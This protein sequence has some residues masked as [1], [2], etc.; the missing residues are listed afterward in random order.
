MIG[1]PFNS[2]G[3]GDGVALAP[4]ALREAGL[5]DGLRAAGVEVRDRGDLELGP[6]SP[7]RDPASHV[8]APAA[9]TGMIRAVRD[10]VDAIVRAERFALVLGGDCPVLL[11]CLGA[12]ALGAPGLLFLDGHEDAWP[13]AASTTGEAA[14]M[15]LGF[16]LGR[17]IGGLPDDLLAE[18]PRLEPGR[19]VVIGARDATE[20]AE[21]GVASIRGI[22]EI[23]GPDAIATDG[24]ERLG[25]A[26]MERLLGAGRG[27]YHVDLDV[28]A[29]ASLRAV[30]YPQPGGLDWTALTALS[31][32]AL[33]HPAVA[34][35]D[36]IIDNPISIPAAP[37][38][39]GS[40]SS[41]WTSSAVDE[42]RGPRNGPD[43]DASGVHHGAQPCRM[44][45]P[46]SRRSRS[47]ETAIGIALIVISAIEIGWIVRTV[48]ANMP[49]G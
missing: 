14:D 35:R 25:T 34:G 37:M 6:T 4:A 23:I 12:P 5:V 28:L 31:R 30:D 41:W 21:A 24:A 48:Q 20:L 22:V 16:A 3:T 44:V 13:P 9:L 38:H 33:A 11:G 2:S 19:V 49:R 1:V 32:G 39:D 27:W 29:T 42:P 36:V 18:L 7:V 43:G 8:I 47:M 17:T 46:R 26:T 10:G 45:R 40:S 15:E